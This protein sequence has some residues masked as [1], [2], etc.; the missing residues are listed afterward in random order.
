[1]SVSVEVT[2][3]S[4]VVAGERRLAVFFVEASV[5]AGGL[6]G[7]AV[8]EDAV[9]L[10]DVLEGGAVGDD[11]RGALTDGQRAE[12]VAETEDLGGGQRDRLERF[13]FWESVSDRH[14]GL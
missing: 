5:A 1:M 9:D 3:L 2:S 13:I 12:L 10:R 8:D 4:A 7:V 11:Q 14:G 6:V